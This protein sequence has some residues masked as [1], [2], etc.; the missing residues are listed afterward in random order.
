ML[1][2]FTTENDL[3][4]LVKNCAQESLHL[5]FKRSP[6][7]DNRERARK[8]LARDAA[9][10]ATSDGGVLLYG[11]IEDPRTHE[12]TGLD[13]GVDPVEFPKEW[14]EQVIHSNVSPSI[15][16][17]H[18]EPI[19]LETISPDRYGYA[20]TVPPSDRAPHMVDHRYSVP[21]KLAREALSWT[22]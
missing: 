3:L 20:V 14:I 11:V 8:E 2:R 17:L 19:E 15:E 7:L 21:S 13:R 4:Q 18:V 22:G 5:D 9:A 12:A 6:A 16:G 10:M 1:Q